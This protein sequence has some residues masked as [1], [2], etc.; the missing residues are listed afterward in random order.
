M[1][2]PFTRPYSDSSTPPFLCFL[3]RSVPRP[4]SQASLLLHF[5]LFHLLYYLSLCLLHFPSLYTSLFSIPLLYF[6]RSL[7]QLFPDI[8]LTPFRLSMH[9]SLLLS[10]CI[11]RLPRAH[12]PS[13][14]PL[15]LLHT[16]PLCPLLSSF[17]Q[18][19]PV[20][21]LS[22]LFLPCILYFFLARRLAVRG[23][24]QRANSFFSSA[25]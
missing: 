9:S 8:A 5:R 20:H 21:H 13:L 7:Q 2:S 15:D 6:L 11:L 17:P 12:F 1:C 16:A 18:S 10:H 25:A 23:G 22:F 14:I 24:C 4:S 3:Y 19:S